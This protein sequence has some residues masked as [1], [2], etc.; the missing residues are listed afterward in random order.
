MNIGRIFDRGTEFAGPAE[1]LSQAALK[2]RRHGFSCLPVMSQGELIGV[3]TERDIVVA[4]A[5][6]VRPTVANVADYM[7]NGAVAVSVEDDSDVAAA[8]M[9]AVGCR[10]LPV[11]D[12]GEL[13]GTVSARD[14]FLASAPRD[15]ELLSVG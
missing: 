3:I 6:G 2:M 4:A 10:H 1:S 11:V 8:K 12:H 13:V 7:N 14:I 15:A 9:L 5:K